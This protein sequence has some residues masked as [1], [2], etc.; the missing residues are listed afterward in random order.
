ML[1]GTAAVFAIATAFLLVW[2]MVI[3]A[4]FLLMAICGLLFEYHRVPAD[5]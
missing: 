1:A 5:H 2:M 4:G 3:A